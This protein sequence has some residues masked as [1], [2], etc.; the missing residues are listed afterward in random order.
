L[1]KSYLD[2]ENILSSIDD[3]YEKYKEIIDEMLEF[4]FNSIV[5]AI[6]DVE[7]AFFIKNVFVSGAPV[8]EVLKSKIAENF[9]KN[10]I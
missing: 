4:L 5:V 6:Q 10:H 9:E 2:I 8:S 1:D 3:N 7:K